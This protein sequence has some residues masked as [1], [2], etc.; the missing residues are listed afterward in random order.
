MSHRTEDAV[1]KRN[2][3]ARVRK[4]LPKQTRDDLYLLLSKAVESLPVMTFRTVK[5]LP[6]VEPDERTT[7]P[8]IEYP[9]VLDAIRDVLHGGKR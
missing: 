6:G 4:E 2:A 5:Y 9:K 1:L 7:P 3:R 8:M